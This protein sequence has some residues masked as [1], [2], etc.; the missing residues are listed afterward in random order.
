MGNVQNKNRI[1]WVDAAKGIAIIFVL[2]IHYD[3]SD[4][5]RVAALGLMFSVQMFFFL[6]GMFANTAKYTIKEYIKR[7]AKAL[8]LPYAVF[9]VINIVFHYIFNRGLPSEVIREIV[10]NIILARRNH[11]LVAAM[12]FLPCLFLVSILYKLLAMA[13]RDK[14]LLLAVCFGISAFARFLLQEPMLVFSANQALRFIVYYSAGDVLYPYLKDMSMESFKAAAPKKKMFTTTAM[15]LL[16]VLVCRLYIKD[17]IIRISYEYNFAFI[18]SLFVNTVVI[19]VFV[20]MLSVLISGFVPLVKIGQNTLGFCCLENIGRAV[21]NTA[22]ALTGIGFW[23]DDPLE[24]VLFNFIA[25][26]ASYVIIVAINRFC[27][28]LFGKS[29]AKK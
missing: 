10:I 11:M 13:I 22:M 25:M 7:Q 2:I 19:I 4:A 1:A 21:V 15:V 5:G 24:V 9:S 26:A 8:M 3:R 14:R 23:A 28:V 27:P 6:S 18:T 29:K 16:A 20:I 17:Y 12:W